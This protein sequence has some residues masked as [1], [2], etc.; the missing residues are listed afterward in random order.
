MNDV[1]IA[2]LPSSFPRHTLIHT[3]AH[4][5]GQVVYV[6]REGGKVRVRVGVGRESRDSPARKR[7]ARTP[8]CASPCFALVPMQVVEACG[9]KAIDQ[10]ET[11]NKGL[12][13]RRHRRRKGLGC[14]SSAPLVHGHTV[15]AC[16]RASGC[17]NKGSYW[18]LSF[19]ATG[20]STPLP[21]S[22]KRS[23]TAVTYM[24]RAMR[25]FACIVMHPRSCV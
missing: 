6:E 19:R 8:G 25:T 14:R 24:T 1:G 13:H 22:R 9:D 12:R 2:T 11:K 4:V 23:T 18:L 10:E 3:Y 17:E 16:G 15:T 7:N 5:V 21:S 20:A